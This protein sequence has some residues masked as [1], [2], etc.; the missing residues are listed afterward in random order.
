M[1]K[2]NL[3]IIDDE[4]PI[5]ESLSGILADE[6]YTPLTASTA[7]EGLEVIDQ[8]DIDRFLRHRRMLSTI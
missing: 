2:L 7:E 5:R 4:A 3:L 1:A 6:G 8:K